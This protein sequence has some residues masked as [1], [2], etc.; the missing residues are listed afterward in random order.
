MDLIYSPSYSRKHSAIE[1]AIKVDMKCLAK[2]LEAKKTR[3]ACCMELQA[4]LE[5]LLS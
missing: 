5:A 1:K 2:R 3:L 4:S